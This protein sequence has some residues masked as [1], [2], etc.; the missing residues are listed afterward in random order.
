MVSF[1]RI[2][3]WVGFEYGLDDH[4]LNPLP[5]LEFN[6]RLLTL[7]GFEYDLDDH[8][9]SLVISLGFSVRLVR[10]IFSMMKD[11]LSREMESPVSSQQPP[12]PSK[13]LIQWQWHQLHKQTLAGEAGI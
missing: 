12:R 4:A 2:S 1:S 13:D 11:F 8:A 10:P 3:V 7:I 9:L 6:L 5:A